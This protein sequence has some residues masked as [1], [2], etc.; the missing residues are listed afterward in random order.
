MVVLEATVRDPGEG[1]R[2]KLVD[3]RTGTKNVAASTG[4]P[5][6]I[7]HF[8]RP[9]MA[10]GHRHCQEAHDVHPPARNRTHPLNAQFAG[11]NTPPHRSVPSDPPRN[12]HGSM[13]DPLAQFTPQVREWFEPGVREPDGRAGAGLARDRHRRARADLRADRLRQDAGRVPLR[14]G[15]LRRAAHARADAARLRLAAEGAVATTSRR[16]CARRC[17]G[18]GADLNVAIRTGD[19]PQK[20]RRDMVKHPPD[21]LITTPESLYLMLTS[22]AR[23]DLRG[24]G[25][26]DPGRDPRGRADQAR[27]APGDHAGA[28]GRAGGP[29]RPARRAVR[30][31]EP[32]RGG[33][34]VHGRAA[35]HGHGRG[36]RACA[37]RWT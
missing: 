12:V 25:D 13:T 37:S 2:T 23:G 24:H 17:A 9:R 16:T 1:P 34:A 19:T 27:R 11:A 28:A 22:Q 6:I 4:D 35:A 15:P 36:H 30:D 8:I 21:V 26:R 10:E 14:A 33:R 32:A 5:R 7:A 20:E 29:R 31:A 18:I 3:G